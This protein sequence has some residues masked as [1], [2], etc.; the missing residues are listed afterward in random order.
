MVTNYIT[1]HSYI[2]NSFKLQFYTCSTMMP[3][4]NNFAI[5]TMCIQT[6]VQLQQKY[7]VGFQSEYTHL[8]HFKFVP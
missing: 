3:L 2:L 6:E 7:E 4:Q 1:Q 5:F 8:K